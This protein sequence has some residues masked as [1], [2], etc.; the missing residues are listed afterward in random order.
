MA[1]WRVI[2]RGQIYQ[3]RCENVLHF[4]GDNLT[5]EQVKQ[6]IEDVWL[7]TVRGIQNANFQWNAIATQQL[8]PTVSPIIVW[9]INA[10]AGSLAG[11]G[12]HPSIAGLFTLRANCAGRACRGRFYLPGIHEDSITDGRIGSGAF[13]VYT[14]VANLLNTRFVQGGAEV[15]LIHLVIAPRL[16]PA[17]AKVVTSVFAR[18]NFG[19]QRRRNIGVG[20]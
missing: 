18:Q 5:D 2:A 12:A 3:Q 4:Q 1:I 10:Q 17:N 7:P 19:I 20:G 13:A 9:P 6:R 14:Q 15:S 16:N 8:A 11:K